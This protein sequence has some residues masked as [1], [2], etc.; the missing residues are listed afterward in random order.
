M[1]DS[2]GI[3]MAQ[4]QSIS[5]ERIEGVNDNMA[6]SHFHNFFELYYLESGER[7]HMIRD[8]V[9]TIHA[10]Q[11]VLFAPYVMHH[12]YGEKDISFKRIVLYFS[13][14]EIQSVQL[15]AALEPKSGVYTADPKSRYSI[16]QLFKMI[17]QEEEENVPYKQEYMH[18][19]LNLLLI[20]IQ[21]QVPQPEQHIKQTRIGQ[22]VD[23]IHTHYFDN[24]TLE[25]LSKEFFVSPYY[26]CREFKRCTNRTI[27]QY[28]NVTRIMNAQRKL[29]ETNCSMT[30]IAN[31]TGFS[32]LTHFNRVFKSNAGI[33]PSEYRK[34]YKLRQEIE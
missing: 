16:H 9:Y 23:Y 18:T 6:K 24:I 30:E 8:A 31:L 28:I 34:Q 1:I 20:T 21:R 5:C 7:Y 25:F 10:G 12:S 19:L 33:T 27:V 29:M 14:S 3:K 13:P 4:G 22:V 15:M 11:F 2:A 32:N 26:L 17:L